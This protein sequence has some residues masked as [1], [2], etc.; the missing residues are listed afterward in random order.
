M[1]RVN[2]LRIGMAA[3]MIE[4]EDFLPAAMDIDDRHA[5]IAENK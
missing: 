2:Q 5:R 3:T 4:A 1:G